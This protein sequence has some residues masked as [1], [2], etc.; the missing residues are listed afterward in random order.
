VYREYKQ[1]GVVFVGIAVNDT[2]DKAKQFV[3]EFDVSFPVGIDK[4]GEISDAFGLYGLPTTLFIDKEGIIS[5]R[6]PGG[7][8]EKLLK[9]ELD[10]IL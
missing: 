7:V 3:V 1:R 8:T 2:E 10:K 9:H 5:Y 4:T 6:H